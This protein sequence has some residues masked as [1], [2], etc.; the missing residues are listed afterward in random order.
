VAIV[1]GLTGVFPAVA[2]RSI[3]TP[4]KDLD[5]IRQRL[6]RLKRELQ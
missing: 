4:K 6:K 1:V 5:L 2:Q 3:K